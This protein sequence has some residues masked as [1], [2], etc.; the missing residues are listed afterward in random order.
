MT[1]EQIIDLTVVAAYL[2]AVTILGLYVGRKKSGSTEDY[3]LGG[4]KFTWLLIGFSLFATNIHMGF[5]VG[6]TGKAVRSGFAAFNPE[7]LGGIM[8]TISALI[9]IPLYLRSKI[10][11]VPQFLELRFNKASKVIFGGIYVIQSVLSSPIAIYTAALG[12]L[13]LFGWEVNAQNVIICGIVI[14]CTVGLYAVLG[15]LTSVV[16]TDMV[17]VVIMIG[18]GTLVAFIGL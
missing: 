3:F 7:L 14:L 6:W 8:L 5:F 10:Y 9:F 12:V 4:R 16:V 13:S 1:T 2:I 11:T 17:Q 15:G 18:G